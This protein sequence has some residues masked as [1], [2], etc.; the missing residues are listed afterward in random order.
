MQ[1]C[2]QMFS[3]TIWRPIQISGGGVPV[4]AFR[5]EIPCRE[6][7]SKSRSLM[8]DLTTCKYEKEKFIGFVCLFVARCELV[9]CNFMV[10]ATSR[11][12]LRNKVA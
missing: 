8:I 7:I 5:S 3:M 10:Y 12:A 9:S 4:E 1:I 11:W 2:F 6:R